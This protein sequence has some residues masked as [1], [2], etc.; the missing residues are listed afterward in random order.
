MQRKYNRYFVYCRSN[1][2]HIQTSELDVFYDQLQ[3]NAV[4]NLNDIDFKNNIGQVYIRVI[5]ETGAIKVFSIKIIIKNAPTPVFS[6]ECGIFAH[7]N[8]LNQQIK[9]IGRADIL[10]RRRAVFY[11]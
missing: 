10:Q 9:S 6:I 4:E 7:R 1:K 8:I 2:L 5:A 11:Q 3:T